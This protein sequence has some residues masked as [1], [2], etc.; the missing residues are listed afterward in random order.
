LTTLSRIITFSQARIP[1]TPARI[2]DASN[3][4]VRSNDEHL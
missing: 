2:S 3:I 1:G 4:L